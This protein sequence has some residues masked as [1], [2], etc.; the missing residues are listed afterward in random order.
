MT[1]LHATCSTCGKD[2]QCGTFP[3]PLKLFAEYQ[4]FCATCKTDAGIQVDVRYPIH[5]SPAAEPEPD[6]P[7]TPFSRPRR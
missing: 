6:L 2:W 4:P 7:R 3:M 1:T 5:S